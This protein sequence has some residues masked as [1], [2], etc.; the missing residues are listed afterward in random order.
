MYKSESI[1]RSVFKNLRLNYWNREFHLRSV[2]VFH[3]YF[4][5]VK[6]TRS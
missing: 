5:G 6:L 4:T 2:K 1:D 3:Q